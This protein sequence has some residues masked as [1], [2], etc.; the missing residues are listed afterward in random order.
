MCFACYQY[1]CT[2]ATDCDQ[3]NGLYHDQA[4][5]AVTYVSDYTALL[6]YNRSNSFRFNANADLGTQVFVT[7][8]FTETADLP[9]T[10]EYNPYGSSSYYTFSAA[11]RANTRLAMEEFSRISGITFVETTGQDTMLQM[12][13]SSGASFGGWANYPSVWASDA[14]SGRLVMNRADAF[15]P[16]SGSYQVLLHELGHAVG[17]SHPFD[18]DI[19]LTA[20]YDNT[21][22]TLMSYTWTG[23]P[24][25]SLRPFDVAAVQHLYGTAR[26]NEGWTWSMDGAVFR[27]RAAGGDDVLLGV[28]TA[29][30]LGGG[31]GN[32]LLRG[33]SANDTL[34]GG[35][36]RDTLLGLRGD[37][38]LEGGDGN[39]LLEGGEGNDRLYGGK[40]HDT[41]DAGW[42]DDRLYGG[43]GNDVIL[44]EYGNNRLYGGAGNDT[45]TLGWGS[46]LASGG[47]GNDVING[48]GGNETL[49]GDA[50]NDTIFGGS[51]VDLIYGGDGDDVLHAISGA[52]TV[53]GGAGD[54]L[55]HGGTSSEVLEGGAGRDTIYGGA[56][57]NDTIFGGSGDDL[58]F[59]NAEGSTVAGWDRLFGGGGN[60]TMYGMAGSDSL[61]GQDGNDVLYGGAGWDTLI[62]GSGDDLIFGG[63]DYDYLYG[64]KGRDTLH[65]DDQADYLY[66][67]GGNDVLYGGTGQDWIYGGAGRDTLYGGADRDYFIFARGDM[68][69]TDR[70]MDFEVNLDRI[71]LQ[72]TGWSAST[73]SVTASGSNTLV[74]AG[75]NGEFSVLLIGV[76]AVDF[77]AYDLGFM[78]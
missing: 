28:R 63:A 35:K 1:A 53:Y 33:M 58:I 56:S 18:Q 45:I 52:G 43:A 39:D 71:Y 10:S 72:G 30:N 55:I 11:Q 65:G 66:G 68:G 31:G 2:G 75:P 69:D 49:R 59:G 57:G 5:G 73:V 36:G 60:D 4:P 20:G 38:R 26:A 12:F 62:G 7:Y 29:N 34:F 14:N 64:G 76:A 44:A 9:S 16:G 40:G 3:P 50:G 15:T 6:A 19:R 25:T 22:Y 23:G 67:G 51:G 78:A 17:L 24:Y 42:G 13:G 37:D 48:G 47:D 41:L 8:S 32:D 27:L 77:G 54:D 46:S 61:S 74:T 70:I 21:A